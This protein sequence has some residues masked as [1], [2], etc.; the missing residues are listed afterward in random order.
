MK[1]TSNIKPV[2]THSMRNNIWKYTTS[3]GGK[4]GHPAVFPLKLAIDH[5]LSWSVDG[6]TILDPFAGSG[7]TGIACVE[8]NRNFIGYEIDEKYYNIAK[9]RIS[10]T[11]GR[12][13]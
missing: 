10:N 8:N 11:Q 7:T 5:I 9:S 13:F 2:P 3:F 4:T 1:R 12:L 6:D